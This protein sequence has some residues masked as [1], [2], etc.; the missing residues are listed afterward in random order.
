MGEVELEI[1]ILEFFGYIFVSESIMYLK[2]EILEEISWKDGRF[3]KVYRCYILVHMLT[4]S[5]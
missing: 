2:I 4:Q 5:G 1:Y 3:L